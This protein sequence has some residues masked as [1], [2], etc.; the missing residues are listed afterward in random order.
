MPGEKEETTNLDTA[1]DNG[2]STDEQLAAITAQLEEE[3]QA[4]AAVE[5]AAAEKEA[6]IAELETSLGEAKQDG[7]AKQTNLDSVTAEL[8]A[9]REAHG[10]AVTRYR[11][12]LVTGHPEIP[13]ELILGESIQALFDSVTKGTAVVNQVKA[14]LD[15]EAQAAKVPAGAP[16][17]EAIAL[18]GLGS[19]EKI[20]EGIKASKK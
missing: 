6:R 20:A 4:R 7:E 5:A 12:A 14:T 2:L 1:N 18:E 19:R 13:A 8:A 11:D 9:A 17:Q 10:Q 15:K 3:K 16:V